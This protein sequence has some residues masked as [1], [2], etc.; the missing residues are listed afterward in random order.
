[1]A[2]IG[3][4]LAI[5]S[6]GMSCQAAQQLRVH[7]DLVRARSGAALELH[8]TPW[9]WTICGPAGVA[10]MLGDGVMFPADVGELET[11]K[12]KPYW[13]KRRCFYWHMKGAIAD[14]GD[15]TAQ[16][17]RQAA[18]LEAVAAARRRVFI[19]CNTQ[20]NLAQQAR[21]Y[22]GFTVG[23]VADDVR[24]LSDA[25]IRRFGP[26]ELV[27]VT[28]PG[29]HDLGRAWAPI[30]FGGDKSQWAGDDRQWARLLAALF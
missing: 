22:G 20:N 30:E 14:H 3:P 10:A 16:V 15:A 11:R 12:G 7:A 18:H 13:A 25:L 24:A 28:H 19:L 29:K 17:A 9:D 21:A 26:H 8:T 5:M 23:L 27:V 1:M 6:V 4:D 2:L